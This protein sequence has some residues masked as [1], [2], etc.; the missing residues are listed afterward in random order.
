MPTLT[1]AGKEEAT[2]TA[3]SVSY[4]MLE[5]DDSLSYGDLSTENVIVQGDNLYALKAILPYY[6][7]RVS[8]VYI[9]PPYN[10]G[11]AFEHYDD[12]VEH[13][14]WLSLM[15][16]RLELLRELLSD[17]GSIFI[18]IDDEEQA[19]LKVLCDEIFG[20]SNFIN[21]ISV[22]MKNIAGASGGG[23]DKRI[24]KNCEYILVY[25]KDYSE[26]KSFNG[27]YVYT[28]MSDLIKQ[29]SEQGK[30]WKYTSVLFQSGDK[31]YIG[32]TNDGVGN[33]IKVYVRRNYEI[34]SI[35]QAATRDKITEKE[36]YR[37]YGTKIFRTTNAQTSIRT[38]VMNFR[39]ENNVHDEL[40]SIEYVPQTGKNKGRV[41]E[42]FYK[43]DICNL[44][45]WLSDTSEIIDGIL[46]KRDLLGTYWDMNAWMK[47]VAKEGSVDF[48]MSKKPEQLVRQIIDMSTNPGDI[49]LDSFLGSGT[50]AAVAHKMNRRYVGIEIGDHAVTHVVPRLRKVIDGEQG[51]ISKAENWQGGGGFSFYR[52]GE[53]VFT[54]EGK[55]RQGVKFAVL[56]AHIWMT[57]TKLPYL[58]SL[59]PNG[60]S[61]SPLI[62]IND[63]VAYYLLYNGIL[64]D[65]RPNGGNVL[66]K[67]VLASLPPHEGTR[68]IY[69][70]SS[71]IH[72]DTLK[73]M[74]IIF[75]QTPKAI[76][77][78]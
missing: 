75:K 6:R 38:R 22:N 44:L 1:W 27:P 70:E 62:G 54:A 18:Q 31:E 40:L 2:R 14:T 37:K 48:P 13:G 15:Y 8:C 7:G 39:K 17:D 57:E 55:I 50:T 74:G 4:R 5:R 23:E 9:D 24:K 72:E 45:V 64:G 28:E 25:A 52:L 56:A 42:Q 34:L 30:S 29:Y 66:T 36:A 35:R 61:D 73:S 60:K 3:K 49:V 69:G 65:K 76:R 33:E 68:I 19:Y 10:T 67:K 21:M 46:Y 59:S 47:N 11:A 43:D 51:G 20:R 63:G 78:D 71:R 12:N 58:K 77:E 16:P 32:S 41:Y 26:I 53:E